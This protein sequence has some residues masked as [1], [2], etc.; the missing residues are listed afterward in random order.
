M[1][2]ARQSLTLTRA[3]GL[4]A[5]SAHPSYSRQVTRT[6]ANFPPDELAGKAMLG[7][8]AIEAFARFLQ[9]DLRGAAD[10]ELVESA[11]RA[12]IFHSECHSISGSLSG[13]LASAGLVTAYEYGDLQFSDED[14][15]EPARTIYLQASARV[16]AFTSNASTAAQ[17]SGRIVSVPNAEEAKRILGV[18]Q[19]AASSAGFFPLEGIANEFVAQAVDW[20]WATRYSVAA[21]GGAGIFGLEGERSA[22]VAAF[23]QRL[24]DTW[25]V[26]SSLDASKVPA[27]QLPRV[28]LTLLGRISSREKAVD[29]VRALRDEFG[30]LVRSFHAH[31]ATVR[32]EGDG[33]SR[34]SLEAER[35]IEQVRSRFF[36]LSGTDAAKPSFVR[37]LG[38]GLPLGGA[39]VGYFYGPEAGLLVS[40][41]ETVVNA[42]GTTAW[43][44][45]ARRLRPALADQLNGLRASG[46]GDAKRSHALLEKHLS[47]NEMTAYLHDLRRR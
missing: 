39:L 44:Q 1:Q 43:G 40:A 46:A 30:P 25:I 16:R 20:D 47:T 11:L 9:R 27:V 19:V 41:A 15:P 26:G 33:K 37:N 2:G 8:P 45:R 36:E 42:V 24:D 4:F 38:L 22:F 18:S 5:S 7:D 6:L 31:L 21:L 13:E 35:E 32:R 12:V 23:D 29:E 17:R 34:E 10:I 28:F 3:M 14:L